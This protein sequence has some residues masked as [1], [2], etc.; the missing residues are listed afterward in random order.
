AIE[1]HSS[2]ACL[3]SM[4]EMT[5]VREIQPHYRVSWLAQRDING[6]VRWRARV[7]L[8]VGIRHLEQSLGPLYSESL[9]L[10]YEFVAGIIPSSGI[11]LGVLIGENRPERLQDGYAGEI[12]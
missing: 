1:E 8:Y 6:E 3:P 7:W 9:Y 4:R 12:L 5:T 2:G 11:A 10:V